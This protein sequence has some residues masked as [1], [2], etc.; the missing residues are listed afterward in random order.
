MKA[1]KEIV[2]RA[3]MEAEIKDSCIR[4]IKEQIKDIGLVALAFVPLAVI[5]AL[6]CAAGDFSL[7]VLLIIA[8]P[9]A[10]LYSMFGFY[11]VRYIRIIKELKE[12]RV[13]TDRVCN[14]TEQ[15]EQWRLWYHTDHVHIRKVILPMKLRFREYGQYNGL[16][17]GQKHEYYRWSKQFQMGD[18]GIGYTT[19]LG[20]EFY[21]VLHG[22]RIVYLYSTDFFEWKET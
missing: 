12:L 18:K 22:D 11:I 15:D 3:I 5:L 17:Y 4:S 7:A 1:K 21:L 19:E 20:E 14:I 10:G 13:V 6:V 16:F 2:T 9:M 8:V